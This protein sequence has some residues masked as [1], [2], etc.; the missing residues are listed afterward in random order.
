MDKQQ[1]IERQ[2]EILAPIKEFC[3]K[4][5]NEEYFELSE[6]LVK[7]LGRK[8]SNPLDGG[9]AKVW[10]AGIIHALGTIN[11][12]FDKSFEP[13]VTIDELNDFFGTKKSTTGQ[14]SKLI[15]ELLKL[16]YFDKE[17][18]TSK[19][20]QSNPFNE[21]VMVDG[22]IVSVDTLP[23]EYQDIVR[24]ARSEGSDVTFTSK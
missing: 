16:G 21:M 1:L 14:K 11:F 12:L 8:K 5:L 13:Y 15:R 9:Q 17:F 10:S 6:R 3:A 18:S 4:K 23:E 22:F 20:N 2:N 19:V 24:Q 7:K